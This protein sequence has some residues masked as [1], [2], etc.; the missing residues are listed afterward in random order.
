MGLAVSSP[1]TVA[2]LLAL[3]M[4]LLK[5]WLRLPSAVLAAMLLRKDALPE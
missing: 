3:Q 1:S 4:C 2:L 5:H